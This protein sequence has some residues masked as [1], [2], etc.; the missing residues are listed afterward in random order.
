MGFSGDGAR[1]LTDLF[2]EN[3]VKVV[4][5]EHFKM[6]NNVGNA[7]I[8]RKASNVKNRK[9][10]RAVKIKMLNRLSVRLKVLLKRALKYITAVP[11]AGLVQKF[12]L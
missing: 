8:F 3:H 1:A 11:R 6:P 7:V 9:Q 4:Y 12:A 10:L 5:A 2:P